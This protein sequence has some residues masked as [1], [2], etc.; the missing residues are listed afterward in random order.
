MEHA[1]QQAKKAT[2]LYEQAQ[3]VHGGDKLAGALARLQQAAQVQALQAAEI[4]KR[5]VRAA[6]ACQV[7]H[8]NADTRYGD[9]YKAAADSAD[10][11]AELAYYRNMGYAN[12]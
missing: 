7:L 4:H 8:A 6:E 2:H 5:A 9:I 3:Q 11:P 1:L 12:A 10:G